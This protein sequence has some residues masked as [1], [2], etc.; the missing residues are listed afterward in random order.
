MDYGKLI[1]KGPIIELKQKTIE[2]GDVLRDLMIENDG[3]NSLI[4]TIEVQS[5]KEAENLLSNG[6]AGILVYIPKNYTVI[7]LFSS[8]NN[9]SKNKKEYT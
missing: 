8:Y 6:N 1:A 9:N 3:I 4:T 7:S 2:F 5:R